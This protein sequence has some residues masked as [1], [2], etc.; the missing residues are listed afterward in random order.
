MARLTNKE[1][2]LRRSFLMELYDHEETQ[3]LYSLLSPNKQQSIHLY[4]ATAKRDWT[5]EQVIGYREGRDHGSALSSGKAFNEL[6][7]IVAST[8]KRL[9]MDCEP[10]DVK[11]L[12][13]EVPKLDKR[14]RDHLR[15]SKA[16]RPRSYK[17]DHEVL[18]LMRQEIDM[19]KLTQALIMIARNIAKEKHPPKQNITDK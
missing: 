12:I 14:I 4:Y 10:T 1:Y 16:P 9:G 13:K 19:N 17:T 5:D 8:A 11:S 18:P 15:A 7:W 6:C 2:L 3:R